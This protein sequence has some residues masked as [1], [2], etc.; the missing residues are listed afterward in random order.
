MPY[1]VHNTRTNELVKEF[2]FWTESRELRI[3]CGQAI[4]EQKITKV[5]IAGE[6]ALILKAITR[7]RKA[8]SGT[9]VRAKYLIKLKLS[10]VQLKHC[11]LYK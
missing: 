4:S 7:K 10:F 8:V 5:F 3:C 6:L 9:N 11:K 2:E 1:T